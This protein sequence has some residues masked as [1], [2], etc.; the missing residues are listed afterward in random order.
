MA[1]A[2]HF[3]LL[4]LIYIILACLE[5]I[6]VISGLW[7]NHLDTSAALT[8]SADPLV[9]DYFT[10]IY[11]SMKSLFKT[12]LNQYQISIK[13]PSKSGQFKL[14]NMFLAIN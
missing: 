13:K 5:D 6:K 11:G 12:N 1:Y 7:P 8:A 9:I 10:L 4:S 3:F 2:T 14:N